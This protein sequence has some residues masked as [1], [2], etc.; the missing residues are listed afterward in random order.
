MAKIYKD[1]ETE[2]IDL[3]FPNKGEGQFNGERVSVKNTIPGQ[4]IIADI[5]KKKGKYEGR[6]VKIVSR[7]PYEN[8]ADCAGFEICGGC[9]Y[10]TISYEKE[11]EFKKKVVLDLLNKAGIS[12]YEY[13][14]IIPSPQT[15]SYRN[16]M[17]FS[18]GDN[19]KD[20]EVCLGMRKRNSNYEVYNADKCKLVHDD[21]KKIVAAVV[22][23][24]RKTDEK[25]YHR[26]KHT[27]SLRH[28]L[29]RRAHYTGEIFVALVTTSELRTELS[30]LKDKILSL[31]T[32]GKIKCLSHIIND[33]MG[34][35]V[36]AD[37]TN[38]LYG[39]EFITE[40]CLDLS[41]KI[42]PF[43]FF[44]TNTLGAEK[45]YSVVRDFAGSSDNK[46]IFD[47][48]CGT[49]T[50][51][52]ILSKN[53]KKVIGIEIVEQAVLAAK[54]NA[55]LNG[56]DNCTFIAGDVFKTVDSL[57]ERPDTIILDPPREGI[58]PKA[59][60]KIA[61]FNAEKI[62]YVSCKASS[63]SKDLLAFENYGYKIIRIQSVDMFPR[64]YHVETVCLLSKGDVKS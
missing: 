21:I 45:L 7:A 39:E 43:S 12:D 29:V 2:I 25:F 11:L 47:L 41:F 15:E 46:T 10:R 13:C 8:N 54:Q 64:T 34:D 5:K 1:T 14:G 61:A 27:G 60:E 6:L 48:Y 9:T 37:K 56:I 53:A 55:E 22:D 35:V 23:F 4:K 24:F 19:E 32:E 44:Q 28:L 62:V 17:E 33:G 40:K 31:D 63:L 49:G 3:S 51:A 50:I 20:G 38:I 59:I 36:K 30:P 18:F 42:T 52:Q 26:M 57:Q 16:K 58:N